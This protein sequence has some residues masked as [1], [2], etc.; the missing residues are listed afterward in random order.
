MTIRKWLGL[1]SALLVSLSL[2]MA[3]PAQAEGRV[4]EHVFNDTYRIDMGCGVGWG[5]VT[6]TAVLWADPENPETSWSLHGHNRFVSDT[7]YEWVGHFSVTL[8]DWVVEVPE[9]GTVS[10]TVIHQ[11]KL[12]PVGKRAAT[13]Q[14]IW[15]S[16]AEHLT[17]V[18]GE[19]KADPSRFVATECEE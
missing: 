6:E 14:T 16:Q 13:R 19:L 4:V 9:E 10:M 7:G 2:G 17:Y 5:T 3:G 8:K 18:D 15:L 11:S 12:N 1:L